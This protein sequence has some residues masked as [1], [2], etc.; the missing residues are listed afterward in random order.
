MYSILVNVK[1]LVRTDGG[2]WKCLLSSSLNKGKS[3]C[4]LE[5]G[6]YINVLNK[7][8]SCFISE[9]HEWYFYLCIWTST[10][11][12]KQCRAII[13]SENICGLNLLLST[14][15]KCI[16]CTNMNDN[17]FLFETLIDFLH[18]VW[19]SWRHG[20]VDQDEKKLH[21]RWSL[22]LLVKRWST[23]SFFF[24]ATFVLAINVLTHSGLMFPLIFF[25]RIWISRR[26]IWRRAHA[27]LNY[28]QRQ[29]H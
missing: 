20:L 18:K 15:G 19:L 14:I 26:I 24:D 28:I 17:M 1:T 16:N 10:Q 22:L 2:V 29:L 6:L 9:H 8:R 21:G 11:Y 4:A 3:I 25:A 23:F 13:T 7:G 5:I 27:S 12:D